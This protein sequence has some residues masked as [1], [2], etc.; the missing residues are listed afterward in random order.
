MRPEIELVYDRDCPN[1]PAARA[2]LSEALHRC[3]LGPGWVEH[4]RS[5]E[6]LPVGYLGYGSPTILIDGEDSIGEAPAGAA[7]PS[8]RLY[9]GERR[10][11][12]V[13][14]VETVVAAIKRAADARRAPPMGSPRRS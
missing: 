1:V 3:G 2:V 12:G 4:E 14:S 13:P 5:Q 11:Q 7:I 6:A 8:C 9:P 10:V